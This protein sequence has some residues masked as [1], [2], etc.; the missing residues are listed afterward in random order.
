MELESGLKESAMIKQDEPANLGSITEIDNEISC[1]FGELVISNIKEEHIPEVAEL[2]ANHATIQ[3]INAPDRYSFKMEGKDWRAFVRRKM[4]KKQ[5]LLLAVTK[6]G[7]SEVRGFLY[8]QA[9]TIPSSN[10]VL[11]GVI[12]DLYTKPQH[13]RQGIA[14]NMLQVAMA[15]GRKQKIRNIE[16]VSLSN[17]K[18]MSEF[19]ESFLK[20]AKKEI[21]FELVT[22]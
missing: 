11:K 13:R 3:Q 15:W 21:S 12:E 22:F 7:D 10:L 6:K 8:L 16:L 1:E 18:Q 4:A 9:I 19:Y 20:E 5:N 17:T 14:T 2:W